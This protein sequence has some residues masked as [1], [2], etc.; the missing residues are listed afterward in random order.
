MDE[1]VGSECFAKVAKVRKYFWRAFEGTKYFWADVL[2]MCV[3]DFFEVYRGR[4][5]RREGG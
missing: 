2:Q 5:E 4:R 1:E 3:G